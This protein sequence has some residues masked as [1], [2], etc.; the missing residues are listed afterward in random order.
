ML[1]YEPKILMDVGPAMRSDFL[2]LLSCRG[3][4]AKGPFDSFE[5]MVYPDREASQLL[6]EPG[7]QIDVDFSNLALEV[8]SMLGGLIK[9]RSSTARLSGTATVGGRVTL[10]LKEPLTN[11]RM[12][13]RSIEVPAESFQ[14]IT[15]HEYSS[16][17]TPFQAKIAIMDDD[18]IRRELQP[19]LE[20]MYQN[21]LSVADSYLDRKEL[22]TVAAQAMEVR[23]KAAI[24]VPK[25]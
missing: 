24:G 6:L 13:A 16:M 1:F 7:L 14:F 21:V 3:Y 22:T 12:W 2:E 20:K 17:M 18:G 9:S 10:S 5:S 25:P 15:V 19:R 8:K 23:K 11:T 4:L